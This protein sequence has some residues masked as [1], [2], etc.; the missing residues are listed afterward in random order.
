MEEK[1]NKKR[2]YK[3]IVAILTAMLIVA[4]APQAGFSAEN[5]IADN[6]VKT[7]ATDP[8]TITSLKLDKPATNT[9]PEVRWWMTQGAH[10][11]ETI[12]ESVKEVA[13]AGFGG[14]EFVMLNDTN[15]SAAEFGYGSE[16]WTH[17]VKTVIQECT[18]YG[19]SAS[20][21]SGTNWNTA[22]VPGLD[23]NDEAANHNLAVANAY[24]ADGV[25]QTTVPTPTLTAAITTQTAVSAVAYKLAADE[26]WPRAVSIS[27]P[28]VF[29]YATAPVDLTADM[30]DGSL[31]FTATGGNWMIFTF[32]YRSTGDTRQPAVQPATTIN[33]F[34]K[35]GF[36]AL[37]AYWESYL[38][39]DPELVDIIRKN[40]QVQMFMDSLEYNN[41]GGGT[42]GNN[43]LFWTKD[44][45]EKFIDIK[46]YDVTPYLPLCLG[47][48]SMF[49]VDQPKDGTTTF[50]TDAGKTLKAKVMDDVRDVLTQFTMDNLMIPLK[51]WLNENYNIKL[52]AQISYGKYLELSQPNI[53]VDYPETETRNQRDQTEFYRV[54]AGA[55]H[56]LNQVL[57]SE[58]GAHDGM[59]YGYSLQEYLQ[60]A[61]TEYAGG[62]NRVIWH[63][64]SSVWAQRN[65]VNWPEYIGGMN[66]INGRWNLRNPSYKDY[67]EY[68]DH[69]GRVQTVL[70]AGVAQVDLAILYQDYAYQLPKRTFGPDYEMGD[71]RQQMHKGYQ[72]ED[73]TLQDA[74]YT[75][76]YFTPQYLDGGYAPY[77]KE[78]GLLASDGPAY[79]ALLIYQEQ[80]PLASAQE[81]LNMARDG[82]KV[83]L[84]EGAMTRTAWNDGKEAELA[85]IRQ[86]LIG[87][88]DVKEVKD[89]KSA[90]AALKAL[91][92]APRAGYSKP[93]EELLSLTRKDKDATYLF[94]YNY[95][96]VMKGWSDYPNF[97]N[98]AHFKDVNN[99]SKAASWDEDSC[100]NNVEV[101]GYLKPYLLDT[102]TGEISEVAKYSYKNGKTVV[103]IEIP[104]GDVR[105]Y[106]FKKAAASELRVA[107][108]DAQE[109]FLNNGAFTVR[110]TEGGVY[111]AQ[112]SNGKTY[113][114]AVD[115]VPASKSLT[116][117]HVKVES[118]SKGD[119]MAPRVENTQFGHV[120]TEYAFTTRKDDLDFDI[121][122][123]KTW[124]N[125]SQVGRNVSGIG[126]YNTT[127]SWDTS[128]AD[129]AYLDLGSLVETATIFVNGDKT[130]S[131]NIIDAV[132]DIPGSMLKDGTNSLEIVVTGP[133]A[134]QL[135]AQGW[136]GANLTE[137]A[138]SGGGMF[139]NLIPD[140]VYTYFDS[141]LPQAVLK[142]YVDSVIY[143]PAA[144]APPEPPVT[145][146]PVISPGLT[147]SPGL[148]P[149]SIAESIAVAGKIA[150]QVWT[151]KQIKPTVSI[152]VSGKRLVAN[153]DYQISYGLNK[154]IGQGSVFVTGKGAYSGSKTI[155]FK[156]IPK[157]NSITKV[158]VGKKSAKV[159]FKKVSSAQKVTGY[160]VQYRQKGTSKWKTKTIS[161]KKNVVTIKGLKKGK[162]YQFRI[163]AYKSVAKV[164]YFAAWSATKN[165]KK[166]K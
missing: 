118:W 106:I 135:L 3:L 69:L 147:Q 22:N 114:A 122:Y 159:S 162:Q 92:V 132:V 75:Y 158:T 85:A 164:N 34:D 150:D 145:A 81:I 6:N 154:N 102:W 16:E 71:L 156:I 26:T 23:L 13:D 153:T 120:T 27:S 7:Q 20:F 109:I 110:S 9:K 94:L 113:T 101:E 62:V 59:N 64:Y 138:R 108:T 141:G 99:F 160:Q 82:L 87:L 49:G 89:Q 19:M 140:H 119:L 78:A 11:D 163:R 95:Y 73:L 52:R 129:G 116:G 25:T 44:M 126:T 41:N 45:K 121:K 66:A 47:W 48:P 79:K 68:N 105:V 93:D 142:P 58:T 128:K 56:L 100:V 137:G 35:A 165:C 123:L 21:T 10:T 134:N 18:K 5:S 91:D 88:E 55:T 115:D 152:S 60:Q 139:G 31:S 36:D 14:I 38:F 83:I 57:S 63:G 76:D 90:Y 2:R 84:V 143:K 61:Y 97:T 33:Y 65:S 53:A 40:G 146:P 131:L 1:M 125:L 50:D 127:F 111:T 166:I 77:D 144:P 4:M 74:G 161:A 104:D 151:G 130:E 72:W 46:G 30:A 8:S 103:P 133:L 42:F 28:L 86:E 12:K 149:V 107:S 37:K 17:D 136:N 43:G 98:S 70:R 39:A 54:H 80:I 29:D 117:W 15:V 148:S 32:W 157:K 24:V 155:T 96:N 67:G 124:N 51:Q 112:L